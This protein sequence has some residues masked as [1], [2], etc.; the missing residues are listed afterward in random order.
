MQRTGGEGPRNGEVS[1]WMVKL[2]ATEATRPTLREDL[3]ADV[4]VIGAGFTGLWAA[5]RILTQRPGTKVVVIEAEH[6]GYGASGRND[7]WLCT[8]M[9]AHQSR[10]AR[11]AGNAAVVDFQRLMV[12]SP[13]QIV[14]ILE[15]EG[16]AAE[17]T[18]SGHL[19]VARTA[20]AW[21]RLRQEHDHLVK[22]GYSPERLQLLDGTE[23]RRRIAAEGTVGGLFDPDTAKVNPGAMVLGLA[24]TVERYGATIF[25]QTR[26]RQVSP[27]QVTLANGA[28]ITA[29]NVLVCTEAESGAIKG[30]P[31]RRIV[32]VNSSIIMTVPLDDAV[33]RR[34]GW[35][36]YECFSDAANV[37]T[38]AQ[39]TPD[40][41]IAIG[42]RGKPYRFGSR[43]AGRGMVD[44]ATITALTAR[45]RDYF[46]ALPERLVDH[47][48]CGSIGVTRDW[49][50]FVHH[51]PVTG[52]GWAGGYAG[53]GVTS[54]FVAARTLVDR[55]LGLETPY[56]A[57]AW[58]GY[59]PP[60]WE[61]EPLRWL[62]IRSMY[63]LFAYADQHEETARLNRSSV[64]ARVGGRLAGL[65]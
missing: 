20:A 59:Q 62:G 54:A 60:L 15:Q 45:L 49:C 50:A 4:C 35:D 53:H 39:R 37:F 65:N 16:I 10:L 26:A 46:P 43:T 32:P 1:A 40:G 61:P 28:T 5:H 19:T 7:G 11:F 47:A 23:A 12:A 64:L 17:A 42:G 31:A 51:S 2:G 9:S 13:R 3:E 58:F 29:A 44:Q 18:V 8:T 27:G 22:W 33:W 30:V 6:V 21:H 41:R 55:M 24:R 34:I 57:A 25:E 56:A 63:K 38:Y 14:E 36:G 48:W 52:L